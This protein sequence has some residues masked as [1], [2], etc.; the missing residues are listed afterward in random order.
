M[1][2][3]L[4]ELKNAVLALASGNDRIVTHN[5]LVIPEEKLHR[6]GF[7]LIESE[8]DTPA[9][10]LAHNHRDISELTY[11]ALGLFA[12]LITD[13]I[14]SNGI[15][16]ITRKHV[17]SLLI[18]AYK[19]GKINQNKLKERMLNEIESELTK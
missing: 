1:T 18:N 12:E 11:K 8:G 13:S 7:K 14:N 19:D 15:Y 17:K 5:V 4:D 6:Y 3:H 10:L 16:T 9:D 2:D